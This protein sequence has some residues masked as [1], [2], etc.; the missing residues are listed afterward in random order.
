MKK[1]MNFSLKHP[2]LS[3][4][5]L[6]EGI[7]LLL[8][9]EDRPFI[10]LAQQKLHTLTS[11]GVQYLLYLAHKVP[12][13]YIIR[14]EDSLLAEKLAVKAKGPLTH[15]YLQALFLPRKLK[16]GPSYLY[17]DF[18]HWS[19]W[20]MTNEIPP[21]RI[22]AALIINNSSPRPMAELPDDP[23][24]SI[25]EGLP[26]LPEDYYLTSLQAFVPKLIVIAYGHHFDQAYEIS[27]PFIKKKKEKLSGIVLGQGFDLD[28]LGQDSSSLSPLV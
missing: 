23:A 27:F 1:N 10:H 5:E 19:S 11:I 17:M 24:A 6:R 7:E 20:R 28:S 18:F 2:D 4:A 12:G 8:A 26:Q 14:I 21:E 15:K 22:K 13:S 16:F 25:T 9:A 3:T